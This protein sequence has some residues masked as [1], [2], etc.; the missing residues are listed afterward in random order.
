MPRPRAVGAR[1]S[2]QRGP[3]Q[4]RR[5]RPR[6]RAGGCPAAGASADRGLP[7]G[8]FLEAKCG[9]RRAASRRPPCPRSHRAAAE[10]GAGHQRRL[11]A[12]LDLGP[13]LAAVVVRKRLPRSPKASTAP[14]RAAGRRRTSPRRA[15]AGHSTLA[16]VV[17]AVDVPRLGGDVERAV[18]RAAM[19]LRW[20]SSS[21]TIGAVPPRCRRRR[22]VASRRRRRRSRGRARRRRTRRRA[23]GAPLGRECTRSQVAPPSRVRTI[24]SSWPTAQPSGVVQPD[25]GQQGPRRHRRPGSTVAAVARDEDVA[26]LADGDERGRRGR[27]RRAAATAR[28]AAPARGARR[29]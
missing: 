7:V 21:P 2:R 28:R 18:G 23:A 15:T 29:A 9:R 20:K 14:S 5:R 11:G 17:G 27:P 1:S 13:R 19:W 4:R 6:R 16:A 22:S 24:V 10:L 25:A 8:Q 12:G 26:A 3:L